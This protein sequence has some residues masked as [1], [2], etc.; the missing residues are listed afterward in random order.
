MTRGANRTRGRRGRVLDPRGN[1]CHASSRSL[2]YVHHYTA[3]RT[4]YDAEM[5]RVRPLAA[6]QQRNGDTIELTDS[7]ESTRR[8][9]PSLPSTGTGT[10]PRILN[11]SDPIIISSGSE[12]DRVLAIRATQRRK[13]GPSGTLG[14]NRARVPP[15]PDA[16]VISLTDSEEEAGASLGGGRRVGGS[17]S[18]AGRSRPLGSSQ[19]V[20]PPAPTASTSAPAPAPAPATA[21]EI[22]PATA[23]VSTPTPTSAPVPVPAPVPSSTSTEL[24]E[25]P[26]PQDTELPPRP[27]PPSYGPPPDDTDDPFNNINF[28]TGG[29]DANPSEDWDVAAS[30]ATLPPPAPSSDANAPG[31]SVV[32]GAEDASDSDALFDSYLN[33]DQMGAD[34]GQ[35]TSEDALPDRNGGLGEGEGEGE[36]DDGAVD[37][38]S[39]PTHEDRGPLESGNTEGP[40][41]DG[42]GD[43]HMQNLEE[44]D[45]DPNDAPVPETRTGT[46]EDGEIRSQRSSRREARINGEVVPSSA[47]MMLTR[48]DTLEDG[49]ILSQRSTRRGV[50]TRNALMMSMRRETPEEGEILSQRSRGGGE[51]R[52]DVDA[53]MQHVDDSEAD[54]NDAPTVDREQ[55][56]SS[57]APPR[58]SSSS[59]TGQSTHQDASM[60]ASA[61]LSPSSP[62]SLF[63]TASQPL[64]RTQTLIMPDISSYKGVRFKRSL[65]AAHEN[66]FFS[67]ALTRVARSAK[68]S[69][70]E[71]ENSG[72]S[73]GSA[74]AGTPSSVGAVQNPNGDA[75]MQ[76]DAVVS[77]P[78]VISTPA[79]LQL[80]RPA[81]TTTTPDA[82]RK[83]PVPSPELS[84][85]AAANDRP[86]V[87]TQPALPSVPATPSAPPPATQPLARSSSRQLIAPPRVPLSTMPMSLVDVLNEVR[88]GKLL[89]EAREQARKRGSTDS[90]GTCHVCKFDCLSLT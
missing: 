77:M 85:T 83:A 59:V 65:P 46:P 62:S 70:C 15:P 69:A 30:F 9:R 37:G 79:S 88:R 82:Q 52:T 33:M 8:P 40:S 21:L 3:K 26:Q 5:A 13:S 84:V 35:G 54:P 22:A 2:S 1:V 51:V 90:T 48:T 45:V 20:V 14:M 78:E 58:V 16:E 50:N 29:D 53:H 72:L 28:D 27:G 32:D 39:T 68:G 7:G 25:Q 31:T 76:V 73:G 38:A 74:A 71:G 67:R 61:L 12:D 63:A 66:S 6:A 56:P 42:D 60:L 24:P 36:G 64:A 55:P 10:Q 17:S 75:D 57:T 47:P 11:P 43:V 34:V 41:A 89:Q 18:T 19:R 4:S 86:P 23:A 49:E 44:G 80:T 87:S 81:K